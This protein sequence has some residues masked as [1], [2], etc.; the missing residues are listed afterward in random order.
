MAELQDGHVLVS[1]T[2]AIVGHGQRCHAAFDALIA[3]RLP[4]VWLLR[5]DFVGRQAAA[6]GSDGER[7]WPRESCPA[8]NPGYALSSSTWIDHRSRG[9]SFGLGESFANRAAQCDRW[10]AAS[11]TGRGRRETN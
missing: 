2:V 4:S 3:V 10:N 9:S 5:G 11:H 7:V 8:W 1:G 6:A